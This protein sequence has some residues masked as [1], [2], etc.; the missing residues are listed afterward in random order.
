[1]TVVRPV[2]SP[3]RCADPGCRRREVVLRHATGVDP[4]WWNWEIGAPDK[5]SLVAYATEAV[6]NQSEAIHLAAICAVRSG[7]SRLQ[8]IV[9]GPLGFLVDV[10]DEVVE[11]RAAARA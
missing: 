5:H 4:L 10:G 3:C 1:M 9:Q 8:Q 7:L 6:T 2:H 11:A